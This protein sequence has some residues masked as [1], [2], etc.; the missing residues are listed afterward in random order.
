[1]LGRYLSVFAVTLGTF[2]LLVLV[3]SGAIAVLWPLGL[4]PL[5]PPSPSD[6]VMM[7]L[8]SMTALLAG[9]ALVMP[10]VMRLG[11]TRGSRAIALALVMLPPLLLGDFGDTFLGSFLS[12]T[13]PVA[14][15]A[16][17]LVLYVASA[18]LSV[19]LYET[20]EL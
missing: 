7:A 4:L 20:R 13:T 5:E 14:L 17:S 16:G 2:A 3:T 15:F 10:F 8:C 19:R 9:A 12:G 6:L 18:L 1:M 11:F